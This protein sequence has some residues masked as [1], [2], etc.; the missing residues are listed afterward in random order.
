M[1]MNLKLT[2]ANICQVR[3]TGKISQNLL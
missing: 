2:H 3:N 1:I